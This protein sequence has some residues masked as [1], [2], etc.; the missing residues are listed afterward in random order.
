M[1]YTLPVQ[2]VPFPSYAGRQAQEKE[3]SE[4]EQI[5]LPSSQLSS[6]SSHSFLSFSKTKYILKLL[7]L[8]HK[9][10]TKHGKFLAYLKVY[11]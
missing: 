3:P 8:C 2:N 4:L 1:K 9:N 5:D 6:S 10:C 11:N 7:M